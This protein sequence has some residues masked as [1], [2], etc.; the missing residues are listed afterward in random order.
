MLLGASVGLPYFLLAATSPLLQAWFTRA[1]PGENPYRLF[2][3]SNLASLIALIGYPFLVEP[4]FGGAQQVSIWSSLFAVGNF[5]YGRT[6]YALGLLAVF[7]VSGLVLL[8]V[9][10]RLWR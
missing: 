5:L 8:S 1:R 2:A 10:R 9:I 4:F 6:E 3:V 7:V